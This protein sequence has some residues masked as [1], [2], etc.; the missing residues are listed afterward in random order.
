[1]FE[2]TDTKYK[3]LLAVAD[4]QDTDI[5]VYLWNTNQ[6]APYGCYGGTKHMPLYLPAHPHWVLIEQQLLKEPGI[7]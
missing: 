6:Q 5:T 1:M 3:P 2:V 7:F 4:L